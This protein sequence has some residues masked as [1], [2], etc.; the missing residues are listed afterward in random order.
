MTGTLINVGAVVSGSLLGMFLGTRFPE[1]IRETVLKGLGLLTLVVGMQM[2]L[3]TGNV[4]ILMGSILIGGILGELIQI[5]RGLDSLGD[6]IQKRFSSGSG[7]RFSEGFVTAS[8]VF[9]VGPLI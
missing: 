4:L 8:L 1:R 2:A 5:Q 3:K 7:D 9:C 6:R